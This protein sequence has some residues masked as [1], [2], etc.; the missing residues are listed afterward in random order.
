MFSD[1]SRLLIIVDNDN[2][3]HTT[4]ARTVPKD[5]TGIGQAIDGDATVATMGPVARVAQEQNIIVV[6]IA[7]VDSAHD[8][9]LIV[10]QSTARLVESDRGGLGTGSTVGRRHDQAMKL[11]VLAQSVFNLLDAQFSA[12]PV[13]EG[14]VQYLVV[15]V[16]L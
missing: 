10:V 14:H 3:L 12:V 5:F 9:I 8:T 7:G 16:G 2:D 11:G 1:R 6:V 13:G 15:V 4:T